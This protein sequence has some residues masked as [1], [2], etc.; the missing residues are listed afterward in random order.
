VSIKRV[1][2]TNFFFFFPSVSLKLLCVTVPSRVICRF[3]RCGPNLLLVTVDYTFPFV[4]GR[5][6]IVCTVSRVPKVFL[7]HLPIIVLLLCLEVI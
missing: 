7:M 5:I 1:R 6:I 3:T 2:S 4:D